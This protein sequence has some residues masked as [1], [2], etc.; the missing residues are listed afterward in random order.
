MVADLLIF[1]IMNIIIIITC[2][3]LR[4]KLKK[5]IKSKQGNL[6]RKNLKI[7]GVNSW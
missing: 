3:S 7:K 4:T 5:K 2:N 6:F 1:F